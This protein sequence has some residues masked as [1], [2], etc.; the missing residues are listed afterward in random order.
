[1][2]L[3]REPRVLLSHLLSTTVLQNFNPTGVKNPRKA[4]TLFVGQPV[5]CMAVCLLL[6]IYLSHLLNFHSAGGETVGLMILLYH[7]THPSCIDICY[8][9][10]I[11]PG[12]GAAP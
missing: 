6:W 4:W 3:K 11:Y 7:L 2:Y 9:P 8:H 12:Y 10:D 5:H 1:M